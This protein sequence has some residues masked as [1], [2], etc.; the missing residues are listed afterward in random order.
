MPEIARQV[1]RS[2]APSAE[3]SIDAVSVSQ[4]RYQ[5]GER[6][7]HCVPSVVGRQS[8]WRP[9]LWPWSTENQR[10]GAGIEVEEVTLDGLVV[11][12]EVGTVGDDRRMLTAHYRMWVAPAGPTNVR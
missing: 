4:R 5:L 9:K 1:Y 11:E 10:N 7:G 2:H 8:S 6:V 3:L 12:A